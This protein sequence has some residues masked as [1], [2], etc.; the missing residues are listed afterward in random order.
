MFVHLGL[1]NWM[2]LTAPLKEVQAPAWR[3]MIIVIIFIFL[4]VFSIITLY[5]QLGKLF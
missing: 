4:G 3:K 5:S 1:V 2:N